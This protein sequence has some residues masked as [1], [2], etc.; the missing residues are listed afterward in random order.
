MDNVTHTIIGLMLSRAGLNRLDTRATPLL[1]M[2]ANI[3]DLDGVS[4]LGGAMTYL[5]MHRGWTHSLLMLPL[6]ACAPV[7]ILRLFARRETPFNWLRAWLI[8]AIGLASHLLLDFTN[9][10]GVRLL[11]PFSGQWFRLDITHLYDFW[12][13]AVLALTVF[14]PW[15]G[16]L[17]SSE[18][19]ARP[20]RGTG[21][22]V[23]ALL[24]LLTFDGARFFLHQRAVEMLSSRIY[25]GGP[26]LR[27]AAWPDP[28]NPFRWRGYVE[29]PVS[30][31]V[32]ELNVL[33]DFDPTEG[34]IFYKPEASAPLE[35]ARRAPVVSDFLHFSQ[36]PAWSVLPASELDNGIRVEVFDLR[37]GTPPPPRFAVTSL[38][39]SQLHVIESKFRF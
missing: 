28:A 27:Y 21:A 11:A 37:F 26:V 10:Y 9:V 33:G 38:L 22:A 12:I 24:F 8:S 18:I 17:V 13:W 31:R 20:G 16:R 34:R 15:I 2:A 6:M 4:W 30:H 29:T 1:L 32:Y 36:F 39:D 23:F 14:G 7:L 35:A 25:E 19:G 5:D 3:P